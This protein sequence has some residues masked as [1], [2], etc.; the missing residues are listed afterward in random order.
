V[1]ELNNMNMSLLIPIEGASILYQERGLLLKISLESG[2]VT[3]KVLREITGSSTAILTV[4]IKNPVI[5]Y[6][7]SFIIYCVL[8]KVNNRSILNSKAEDSCALAIDG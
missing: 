3:G 7:C 8:F 5:L 6:C 1:V 4:D 2:R